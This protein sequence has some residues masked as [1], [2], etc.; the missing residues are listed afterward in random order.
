MMRIGHEADQRGSLG[1]P[2][3][4]FDELVRGT[5]D[6]TD[7]ARRVVALFAKDE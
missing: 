4:I 2:S 3:K 1:G 7:A 6:V 5:G